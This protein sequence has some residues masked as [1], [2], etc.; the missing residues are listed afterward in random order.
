M[1]LCARFMYSLVVIATVILV[2]CGPG[3][4]LGRKA[5]SGT[6][7]LDGKPLPNGTIMFEP[8][9]SEGAMAGAAVV[10]GAFSIGTQRGLPTGTY[11]VRISAGGSERAVPS[12]PPGSSGIARRGN[13]YPVELI[14]IEWNARSRH[15]VTVGDGAR[16]FNFDIKSR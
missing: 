13:D 2:G 12:G 11:I 1:W 16:E 5:V 9:G 10:A 15:T 3:N 6:V 8:Q 7:T 14:P 4:P